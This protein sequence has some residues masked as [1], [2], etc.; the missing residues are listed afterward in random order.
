MGIVNATPDSFS[1][2]GDT[3]ETD[4]AVARGLRQM[5]DGAD[6][7]D[8]GGE[9]TRPGAAPVTPDEEIRRVLPD[10]TALAQSGAVVSIDTRHTAVMT[11]AV[12][13]GARIFNDVSAL[14]G[15]PASTAAVITAAWRVSMDTTA[16]A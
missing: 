2:G 10:V 16:P 8:I 1:D 11:A 3:F 14:A 4:D 15:D 13:A 5:R 9:S 6:I 7:I 12:E